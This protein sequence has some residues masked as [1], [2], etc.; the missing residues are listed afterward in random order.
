MASGY[1]G[2]PQALGL[3]TGDP[4][5]RRGRKDSLFEVTGK[6]AEAEGVHVSG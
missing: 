5:Q 2:D 6:E 1:T 4:C 3:R